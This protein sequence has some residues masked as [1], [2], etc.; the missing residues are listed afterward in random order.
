[1]HAYGSWPGHIPMREKIALLIAFPEKTESGLFPKNLAIL[2]TLTTS[3]VVG[4][5]CKAGLEMHVSLV[6][7]H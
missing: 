6:K 2:H 5:C 3:V 4:A 1:M 7:S